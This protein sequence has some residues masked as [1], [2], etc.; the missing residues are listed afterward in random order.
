MNAG[1]QQEQQAKLAKQQAEY[2]AREAHRRNLVG[3]GRARAAWGKAG[4]QPSSG[5][6]LALIGENAG[7]SAY[8]EAAILA[9]GKNQAALLKRAGRN[10]RAQALGQ[11]GG[12]LLQYSSDRFLS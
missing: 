2:S 5:S 12:S 8:E 1:K 3:Q 7:E 10:V 9:Q 4:V 6:P 11:A